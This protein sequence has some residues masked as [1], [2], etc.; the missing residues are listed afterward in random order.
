MRDHIF[1]RLRRRAALVR[2]A[3][4]P[5]S[6]RRSGPSSGASC[7]AHETPSPTLGGT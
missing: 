3:L 2:G 1:A 6:L 4:R 7:Y 5:S